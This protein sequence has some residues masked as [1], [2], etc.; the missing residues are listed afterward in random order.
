MKIHFSVLTLILSD[1]FADEPRFEHP[2][3]A[4]CQ[5]FRVDNMASL[6]TAPTNSLIGED[7]RGEIVE[8][9]DLLESIPK[10]AESRRNF[11]CKKENLE[12]Y[13]FETNFVYTFEFCSSFFSPARHRLELAPLFTVDLI[14]F[15]NRYP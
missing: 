6:D 2:L 5:H 11:F 9:T 4:G 15:F 3:L 7:E 13:H 14:P 10:S 8:N 12:K 1:L